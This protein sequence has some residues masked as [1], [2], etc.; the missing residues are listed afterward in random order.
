M[1]KREV[2]AAVVDRLK[3]ESEMSSK[4]VHF[5]FV[6]KV[7]KLRELEKNRNLNQIETEFFKYEFMIPV[8]DDNDPSTPDVMRKATDVREL[9][10]EQLQTLDVIMDIADAKAKR[11]YERAKGGN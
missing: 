9:S 2:K 3:I 6:K 7:E 4:S 5:A 8:D 10:A 1:M 11:D